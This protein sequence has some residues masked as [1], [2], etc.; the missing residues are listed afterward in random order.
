VTSPVVLA[1]SLVTLD[2]MQTVERLLAC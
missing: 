1:C 2:V